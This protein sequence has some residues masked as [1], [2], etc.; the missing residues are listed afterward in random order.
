MT[1]CPHCA[2]L[3]LGADGMT[4]PTCEGGAV[5]IDHGPSRRSCPSCLGA[6][7]C[8]ACKG[9]GQMQCHACKGQGVFIVD[10]QMVVDEDSEVDWTDWEEIECKDCGGSGMKPGC[11]HCEQG[12]CH[13][14]GGSGWMT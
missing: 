3:G 10:H 2:G 5:L 12:R 11:R 4:C 8:H 7:V 9:N 13:M 1:P 14:C 6:G